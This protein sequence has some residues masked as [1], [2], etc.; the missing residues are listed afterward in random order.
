MPQNDTGTQGNKTANGSM[1]PKTDSETVHESTSIPSSLQATDW[2][3]EWKQLQRIRRAF[4]DNQYW[5]M[6]SKNFDSNDA[7]SAYVS[8]FLELAEIQPG[9]AVLDMGC[10]TGSIAVPLARMGCSVIAADFSQG[11]LGEVEKRV[12][13]TGVSGITRK[14]LAWA[15]DWD[16]AGISEKSVDVAIASRSIS[17]DDMGG[18]LD[19]L[20]GVAR[21][22]C[23]ISLPTGCSPRTDQRVLAVCGIENTHGADHQYAWN[24]LQNKGYLP[25]CRY[26]QS[27]RKDTYDSLEEAAEDMG[28]MIDDTLDPSD[29]LRISGAKQK[30][31]AWLEQE[32]VTNEEEGMDNG[33]GHA[34]KR[35]RLREP[36]IINWA[37]ISW[38]VE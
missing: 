37:F 12:H 38:D 33:K 14:L 16:A 27:V 26:I 8:R 10:G 23:C 36:R 28:R 22:R 35:L 24:I 1:S 2:N 9:E 20:I 17:T 4:D 34:Q 25:E 7:P 29:G 13:A 15:D 21:R 31:H 5:N 11:M 3:E 30:L 6:R 19:K 18:A 32:L